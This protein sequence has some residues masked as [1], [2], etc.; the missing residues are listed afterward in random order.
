V[1]LEI[2]NNRP[3]TKQYYN[4]DDFNLPIVDVWFICSSIPTEPTY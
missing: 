1:Y 3:R 2:N 4:R